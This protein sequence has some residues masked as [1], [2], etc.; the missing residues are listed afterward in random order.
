MSFSV[1]KT[2]LLKCIANVES[3]SDYSKIT[4]V[5]FE[6]GAIVGVSG[7]S[8]TSTVFSIPVDYKYQGKVIRKQFV[9]KRPFSGPQYEHTSLLKLYQH[10]VC[11][12]H[13]VL[14]KITRLRGC[15][16]FPTHFYT[17]HM[18]ELFLENLCKSGYET[19]PRELF[20]LKQAKVCLQTLAQF[21][22]AS[23]KL[24]QKEQ[25]ITS[26]LPRSFFFVQSN[27][28]S[29]NGRTFPVLLD[30]LQAEG[31][32]SDSLHNFRNCENE[33]I[34]Q[35]CLMNIPDRKV[36]FNVL[37]HTDAKC[38]N[39]LIRYT[40]DGEPISAKIIDHQMSYFGSPIFDVLFFFI[41][42]VEFPVFESNY[43]FLLNSYLKTLNDT[44]ASLDYNGT[45]T[46]LNYETDQQ[47]VRLY[48][49]GCLI[50]A[51][52]YSIRAVIKH[53]D[54]NYK[55]SDMA[56]LTSDEIKQVLANDKFRDT[57]L[58][59]FQYFESADWL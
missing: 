49:F 28:Q 52:F 45:Y 23:A 30:L 22:A 37:N 24:C 48:R 11:M 21:H 25:Y 8:Y 54:F 57:F 4:I 40:D 39:F 44:L 53:F 33:I 34:L 15:N 58:K 10:E 29:L 47:S 1:D 26:A 5:N 18:R 38:S 27:I 51:G 41:V 3:E 20:N 31:V 13:M 50:L 43:E 55:G 14:P 59:L 16:I 2:T 17:S 9:V 12:Y 56:P 35:R 7:S 32:A 42:S 46:K 6:Q 19:E 36:E